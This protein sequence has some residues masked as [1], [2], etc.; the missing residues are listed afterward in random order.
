RTL[1]VATAAYLRRRGTPAHPQELAAHDCLAYLRSGPAHWLFER[2]ERSRAARE[3]ERVSV[4]VQGPMRANNSEVLRDAVL[5]GL[6]V[7][8]VPDFSAAA[9]LRAGRLREVLPEWRPVG[10]FGEAI[11]AIRPWSPATPRAVQL[12]VEH[13]REALAEGFAGREG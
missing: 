13:L 5:A 7:A 4:A 9:A 3:P 2:N 1:L 8:Q 6:G 11:Y 10:F 12:V